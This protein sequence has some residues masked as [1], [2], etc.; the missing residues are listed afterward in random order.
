[1]FDQA[2]VKETFGRAS[3]YYD[4]HADLQQKVRRVSLDLA[5]ACWADDALILDVGCGTGAF[6]KE[7]HAEGH[8][9][10]VAGV[11]L[12][13]GMC[14]RASP[15]NHFTVNA[16]AQ[17]LPF[18]DAW[19]DGVFS[20]LMLQWMDNPLPALLEFSRLLKPGAHAVLSTF[21]AGTLQELAQAFRAIDNR[22]H[23]SHFTEPHDF[24]DMAK[25][26]GLSLELA[27]QVPMV[28]YYP[29]TVALMRSLQN[30]GATNKHI[31]RRR[32]LMTSRQFARL[33]EAY[34]KNHM[35]V[36][37]LPATWNILF[38]VLRKGS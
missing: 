31:H 5:G 4:R 25:Q 32:G 34:R 13:Y 16:T 23:V 35:T 38:V 2:A 6:A 11:D 18:A 3:A 36:R 21:A 37:G 29:D 9:W 15:R 20:S 27:Q 24:L 22:P 8:A 1:M 17:A 19:F 28:E 7:A 12:A 14:E 33:E 10:R 30:I 26:A